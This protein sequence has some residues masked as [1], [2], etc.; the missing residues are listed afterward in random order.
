M[1]PIDRRS[2]YYRHAALV[3]PHRPAR[4]PLMTLPNV[5]TFLRLLLV[6]VLL[7]VWEVQHKYTPTIC[8]LIF[9]WASVTD[10]FD[11]YLAR[12]VG[13]LWGSGGSVVERVGKAHCQGGSRDVSQF[14]IPEGV[15]VKRPAAKGAPAS[16]PGEAV[17]AS[18][19]AGVEL[20]LV[21]LKQ[22]ACA[23]RCSLDGL[24]PM[25]QLCPACPP[26]INDDVIV[27]GHPHPPMSPAAYVPGWLAL[28]TAAACP[29]PTNDGAILD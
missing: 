9:I 7:G 28:G 18:A 29:P 2:D 13:A 17:R 16:D 3:V 23:R 11:G 21:L 12:K 27:N 5:L 6:P 22:K 4:Q 26:P 14:Q 1:S 24:L 10:Y 8:A 15:R 25:Q 20:E 19:P